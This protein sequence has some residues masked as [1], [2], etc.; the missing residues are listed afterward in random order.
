MTRFERVTA[1]LA[2][3]AALL[4]LTVPAAAQPDA[5]T[6]V[7]RK[8]FADL[9]KIPLEAPAVS[10]QVRRA[11]IEDGVRIE[12]ISW[13]SLD[14]ERVPA[15]V[16]K[17]ENAR[18]RLPAIVCL[19][20]SGGSRESMTTAEFGRGSWT[21]PGRSRSHTRML[22]WARELA[23]RGYV[24]LA[25]T[26]RG[27]DRRKPPINQQANVMLV[28]GRTAMGAVLYEIRQ[29][30]THLVSRPDVDPRRIGATGMSFGGITAFYVWILDDRVAAAAPICGGVGSVELFARLGSIGYHGTYWWIPGMLAKGDQADFAAAVAP[31]PLM[32]WAPTEDIGMPKQ[33]VD[34]FVAAVRPVY[35]KAGAPDAFVVHQPPGPHSFTPEAFDAMLAFFN[36]VF[37]ME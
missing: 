33:A 7:A 13:E 24:A 14:G 22:G 3:T 36:R 37:R 30:V 9:L 11:W 17:P 23:R 20:G 2:G 1:A 16:L 5:R 21:T 34:R 19:H 28:H 10:V 31:K 12:D 8:S 18:G 35:E 15:F 26:Q 27:L 4:V 32:L 25:L 29:G 6:Y